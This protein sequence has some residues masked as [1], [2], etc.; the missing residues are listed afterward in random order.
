M[1][2]TRTWLL[3]TSGDAIYKGMWLQVPDTTVR[4]R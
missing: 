1:K 3:T 2:R 4:A